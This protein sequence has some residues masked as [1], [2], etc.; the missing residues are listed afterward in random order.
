MGAQT[1]VIYIW[2][3]DFIL[4]VPKA[5]GKVKRKISVT[6]AYFRAR[7]ER[8]ILAIVRSLPPIHIKLGH[9]SYL[10]RD[11]SPNFV[12][13]VAAKVAKV[14]IIMCNKHGRCS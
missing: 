11:A 3:V 10:H 1:A 7:H 12:L 13:Y 5:F 4:G 9:F 8:E 2:V 6:S 14:L